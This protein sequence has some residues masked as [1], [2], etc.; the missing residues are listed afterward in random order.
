MSHC[1]IHIIHSF[2]FLSQSY[3]KSVEKKEMFGVQEVFFSAF[4]L[5]KEPSGHEM[6]GQRDSK[7][8]SNI[9]VPN[10]APQLDTMLCCYGILTCAL[11]FDNQHF[12]VLKKP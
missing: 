4:S 7:N 10:S 9:I 11:T 1:H 3:N 12:Y 5:P 8:K 6:G 2:V